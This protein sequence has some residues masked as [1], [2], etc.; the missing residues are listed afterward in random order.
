MA[1]IQNMDAGEVRLE[2]MVRQTAEATDVEGKQWQ[3]GGLFV[4]DVAGQHRE[5]I[6][7]KHKISRDLIGAETEVEGMKC[8]EARREKFEYMED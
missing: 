2:K 6:W 1:S 5:G 4:D 8:R 7:K 3:R